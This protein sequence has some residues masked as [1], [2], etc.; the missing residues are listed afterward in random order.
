[1]RP[2]DELLSQ[3]ECLFTDSVELETAFIPVL[4]KVLEPDTI[5]LTNL[6]GRI[7]IAPGSTARI[8][9]R[10]HDVCGGFY[11]A[12]VCVEV[13]EFATSSEE[14]AAMATT[15]NKNKIL[16]VVN[17]IPQSTPLDISTSL[18]SPMDPWQR[19]KR[20]HLERSSSNSG[21]MNQI[22][23][24][25][26]SEMIWSTLETEGGKMEYLSDMI[27]ATLFSEEHC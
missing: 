18:L 5:D 10:L 19:L 21:S 12:D 14:A 9:A 3:G 20:M 22:R 16:L 26:L 25:F 24:V 1:M 13:E 8:H 6:S 23:A 15:Q 17:F 7:R 11:Q 4:Q 2:V 27:G